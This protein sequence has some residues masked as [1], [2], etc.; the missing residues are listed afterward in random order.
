MAEKQA[1]TVTDLVSAGASKL[2]DS[3]KMFSVFLLNNRH[4][5]SNFWAEAECS[6]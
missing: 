3:S 1:V 4:S 2:N 5:L 6:I